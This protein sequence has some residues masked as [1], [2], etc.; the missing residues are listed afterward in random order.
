[1]SPLARILFCLGASTVL[2]CCSSADPGPLDNEAFLRCW[3]AE[4]A[5]AL[6]R[7]RFDAVIFPQEGVVSA[8]RTCPLVRL[9]LGFSRALYSFEALER[10]RRNRSEL[11]GIRG[12]ALVSIARR[13]GPYLLVVRVEQ[14]RESEILSGPET[15]RLL[16]QM[17]H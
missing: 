3:G 12:V 15:Q 2:A 14:I 16:R 7:I 5:G 11:I 9:E 6:R 13:T 1:M 17:E 4:P 10:A 8:S